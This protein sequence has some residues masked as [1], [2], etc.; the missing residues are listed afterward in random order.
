MTNRPGPRRTVGWIGGRLARANPPLAALASLAAILAIEFSRGA[1]DRHPIQKPDL[2]W[3]FAAEAAAGRAAD[4]D[5]LIFGDSI[6]KLDAQPLVLDAVAGSTSF[7]LAVPGGQAPSSYLLLDRALRSGARPRLILLNTD[8]NL[9]ALS[10]SFNRDRWS[11]L[12][13]PLRSVSLGWRAG[14]PALVATALLHLLPSIRE[15]P[16]IRAH[17]RADLQGL[18]RS[19]AHP[20]RHL[21]ENWIANRGAQLAAD[22]P[23]PLPRGFANRAPVAWKPHPANVT[24]INAFLDL[25]AA[26]RIRVGWLIPPST[27]DWS[28]RRRAQGVDAAFDRWLDSILA[29]HDH[30]TRIDARRASFSDGDFRDATHFSR[31]GAIRYSAALAR[32]I[33]PLIE[34]HEFAPRIDLA[35][36]PPAR[37]DFEH[38]EDVE[39]TRG[40]LA[41]GPRGPRR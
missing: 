3:Q 12:A 22:R 11:R 13:S 18:D 25:A 9:L 24:Y 38:L 41:A 26:H 40:R 14:D 7:N 37:P 16:T 5:V 28:A 8:P 17:A 29:A 19:D 2:A 6:A 4:R 10:P 32:S 34:G 30:V 36:S 35:E 33:R 27:G 1:R 23:D 39:G 20:H 21:R 31:R 15:R